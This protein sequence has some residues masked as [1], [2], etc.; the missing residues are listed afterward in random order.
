MLSKTMLKNAA[1]VAMSVALP[2]I[3]NELIDQFV[4]GPMTGEAVIAASM[5]EATGSPVR[6]VGDVAGGRL[7][8]IA[9]C[10]E[11][12]HPT[13]RSGRAAARQ[14]GRGWPGCSMGSGARASRAT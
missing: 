8:I 4:T 7:A 10:M 12:T 3:L 11:F 14:L 2:K 5:A 6:L 1:T 9:R 13:Q